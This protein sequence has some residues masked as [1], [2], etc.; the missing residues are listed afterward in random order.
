M[1]EAGWPPMGMYGFKEI[2]KKETKQQPKEE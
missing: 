2:V 1:P